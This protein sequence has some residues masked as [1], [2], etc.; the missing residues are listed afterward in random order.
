M[1]EKFSRRD[2][3]NLAKFAGMSMGTLALRF[4]PKFVESDYSAL[5]ALNSQTK[6]AL[7]EKA[8]SLISPS[9]DA[10]DVLAQKLGGR[11]ASADKI[12]GPL[13]VE[14]LIGITTFGVSPSDFLSADI[15]QL[16]TN[17]QKDPFFRTFPR[18]SFDAFGVS[19]PALDFDFNSAGLV[20]G[21]FLYFIGEDPKSDYMMTISR[22]DS[23][24]TLWAVVNTPQESGRYIISEVPAWNPK[25]PEASF[26]K[27]L[28]SGNN[29]VGFTS[30]QKG[31]DLFRL[32][33]GEKS[34][35]DIIDHSETAQKLQ[36]K[37]NST[38]KSAKGKW[39]VMVS[40][41]DS[42]KIVAENGSR[43]LRYSASLTKVP[44]AM[45]AL[46]Y[47]EHKAGTPE[48]LQKVLRTTYLEGRTFE[49]L[50]RAMLSDASNEDAANALE[51][52]LEKEK[53]D[54]QALIASQG[55]VNT[56]IE[57]RLS[58]EE[59]IWK[60]FK[61][62]Y[63][64]NNRGILKYPSSHNFLLECM[65]KYDSQAKIWLERLHGNPKGLDVRN[66]YHKIG[67]VN[68]GDLVAVADS[69]IVEVNDPL[70]PSGVRS[71]FISL[72]GQ[73]KKGVELDFFELGAELMTFIDVF[74]GYMSEDIKINKN[75]DNRER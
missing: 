38:V 46:A 8:S 25:N 52:Y 63:N 41:I 53:V 11:G 71:Y 64:R 61:N 51:R 70:A 28:A 49:S 57:T 40:N 43:E 60:L 39:H 13:A 15:R 22:R 21:D 16:G 31:F 36:E 47:L 33:P 66:I 55:I 3:L 59:D 65:S 34:A 32:K 44:L 62:L 48:E 20:P 18:T 45:S 30:G 50:F 37:I 10:A 19:A 2:F 5:D 75:S 4:P 7:A 54:I 29:S 1:T 73:P 23:L 6:C 14:Q 12:S 69:G 42:G 26:I 58:T 24:G 27:Q 35:F 72:N 67:Y 17:T 74:V 68:Y 56:N 9:P